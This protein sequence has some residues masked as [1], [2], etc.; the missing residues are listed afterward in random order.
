MHRTQPSQE[1]VEFPEGILDLG[2]GV[3]K[4]DQDMKAPQRMFTST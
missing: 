2:V 3:C 1:Q 4:Y